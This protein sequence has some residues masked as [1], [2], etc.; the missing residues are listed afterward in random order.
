MMGTPKKNQRQWAKRPCALRER[1]D[2]G[3]P[4]IRVNY[5][6]AV[7]KLV[8]LQRVVEIALVAQGA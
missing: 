6:R 2:A 7:P 4:Q 5:L 1:I 3:I 8:V